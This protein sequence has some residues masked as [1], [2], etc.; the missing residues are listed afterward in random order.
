[1]IDEK[2]GHTPL[3]LSMVTWNGL[4]QALR[5]WQKNKVVYLKA[6]KSMHIVARPA[7]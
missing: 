1:M 5:Q 2:N 4:R 7:R 6:S 3:Q